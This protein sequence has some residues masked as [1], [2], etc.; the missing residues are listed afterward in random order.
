MKW[1]ENSKMNKKKKDKKI[2][3]WK[4]W[5]DRFFGKSCF[6][7]N[8]FI[9]SLCLVIRF[10]LCFLF[11]ILLFNSFFFSVDGTHTYF[12]FIYIFVLFCRPSARY[13]EPYKRLSFTYSL[14]LTVFG[15]WL[16]F[17]WLFYRHKIKTIVWMCN[18]NEFHIV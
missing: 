14:F 7:Y 18:V 9:T 3:D 17:S 13:F 1:K 6:L 8:F 4:P 10:N 15:Y 5:F 11:L 12:I 2:K 16:K